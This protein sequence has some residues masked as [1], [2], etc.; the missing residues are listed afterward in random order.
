M[1]SVGDQKRGG[2]GGLEP[3][4][5]GV[6][7]PPRLG[8]P[9][10]QQKS[11]AVADSEPGHLP[12]RGGERRRAYA[13]GRRALRRPRGRNHDAEYE[14]GR[15]QAGHP[16]GYDNSRRHTRASNAHLGK[17]RL[18]HHSPN[19]SLGEERQ[20]WPCGAPTPTSRSPRHFVPG[21]RESRLGQCA[22]ILV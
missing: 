2:R 15:G 17:G 9:M 1:W 20:I 7:G 18:T 11:P 19:S 8:E 22:R 21:D 12:H 4:A 14:G 3:E 13:L 10:D 5:S 16:V 6:E